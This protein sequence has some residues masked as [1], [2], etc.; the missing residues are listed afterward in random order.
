MSD[1]D[2]K[3]TWWELV[4]YSPIFGWPGLLIGAFLG[5]LGL[6]RHRISGG[7]LGAILGNFAWAAGTIFLR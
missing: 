2:F 1:I 5:A 7:A 6:K 3:F 4:L